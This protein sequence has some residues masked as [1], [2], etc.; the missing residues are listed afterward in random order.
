V[1]LILATFAVLYSLWPRLEL[2]K[3][4]AKARQKKFDKNVKPFLFLLKD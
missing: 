1:D 4:Y 3:K 2:K